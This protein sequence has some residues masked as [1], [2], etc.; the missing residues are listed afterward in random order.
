M[1]AAPRYNKKCDDIV[2]DLIGP[3]DNQTRPTTT[4]KQKN[5]TSG[6]QKRLLYEEGQWTK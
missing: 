4:K 6:I 1:P 5:P 2:R 3:A